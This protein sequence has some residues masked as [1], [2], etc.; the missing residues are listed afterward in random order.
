MNSRQPFLNSKRLR[1]AF[2]F[3]G[4]L[5]SAW[6]I[7]ILAGQA[8][9]DIFGHFIGGD[10]IQF[11]AAGNTIERE[12]SA[13]LYDFDYQRKIQEELTGSS[14]AASD[15]HYYYINPPLFAVLF[16][17]F[18]HLSFVSAFSL[19]S[20]LGLAGLWLAIRLLGIK[21]PLIPFLW[22]LTW[23]PVFASI[24]FG[25]NGLLSLLLLSLTFRLRQENKS[26]LAGFIASFMLFKPQLILGIILLWI[27]D[28]RREW[29]AL[30][31]FAIGSALFTGISFWLL[32]QATSDYFSVARHILPN[33]TDIKGFPLWGMETIAVIW[34][35]LLPNKYQWAATALTWILK[36][37]GVAGFCI[38]WR[39]HRE[40]R[41]LQ[42]VLA[43][44]LTFMLTPHAM[45]YDV[46]LLL[47]P[48]ILLWEGLPDLRPAWTNC[49]AVMWTAFA[50]C[51]QLN[52]FQLKYFSVALHVGMLGFLWMVFYLYRILMSQSSV[53]S[54]AHNAA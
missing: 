14:Y 54:E 53:V 34:Q 27:L 30:S 39:R 1:Y 21:K 40:N 15:P 4:L 2:I 20:L 11:Y 24:P 29:K 42:F 33:L 45:I 19:W 48:A 26:S 49:F 44:V 12:E 13:H 6:L 31:G 8:N 52:R 43:I 22:S 28:L 3:G 50:I 23:I 38:L 41:W 18:S 47:I 32:P 25:Q 5:W 9:K 51:S 7:S 37:L 35:L 46:G 36:G 17:P 10:F 16:R